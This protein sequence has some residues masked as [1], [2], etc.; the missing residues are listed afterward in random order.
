MIDA[1]D[2]YELFHP[3]IP[4]FESV[5]HQFRLHQG[6]ESNTLQKLKTFIQSD[7]TAK[8]KII[9]DINKPVSNLRNKNI[10]YKVL[11]NSVRILKQY[12]S[13]DLNLNNLQCELEYWKNNISSEG[14]LGMLFLQFEFSKTD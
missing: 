4:L 5:L 14:T 9:Q 8:I 11:M 12:Y 10:L 13:L 7:K 1:C 6:Q 2:R 3:R